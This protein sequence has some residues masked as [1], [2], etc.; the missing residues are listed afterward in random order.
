[1]SLKAQK[2]TLIGS[3]ISAILASICCLGPIILAVLGISGAGLILKFEP[4]RPLFIV[5]ATIL[6][7][8]GFYLTYKKKPAEQCEPGTYCANPKSD[9]LNK[10][11][12]W[13]A[14]ILVAFF[15][16]F[17]EIISIFS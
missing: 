14:A 10:I 2:T 15:V 4:Y 1:M 3:I 11:I 9:R 7:G 12:L 16:F 6:L 8:T 17:P 13:V 5:V